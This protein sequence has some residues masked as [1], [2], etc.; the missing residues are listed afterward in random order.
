MDDGHRNATISTSAASFFAM[1]DDASPPQSSPQSTEGG[2]HP[3]MQIKVS[4]MS[5]IE[6]EAWSRNSVVA[7]D[8]LTVFFSKTPKML[9]LCNMIA[10]RIFWMDGKIEG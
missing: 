4:L 6:I 3:E 9:V 5:G 7:T 8:V 1:T 10:T 2:P